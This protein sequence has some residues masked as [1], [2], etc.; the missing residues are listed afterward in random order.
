MLPTSEIRQMRNRVRSLQIAKSEK[1][2][3]LCSG[4][5]IERNRRGG[6]ILIYTALS[7]VAMLGCC[8]LAVDYGLQVSDANKLQRSLDAAALAGAQELK[9]NYDRADEAK[10]RETAVLTASQNGTS[11]SAADDISFGDGSSSITVRGHIVR[12]YLFA[13]VFNMIVPGSASS[14]R[15]DRHATARV[16]SCSAVPTPRVVPIGIT[17]DTYGGTDPHGYDH[18]NGY[19]SDWM[20]NKLLL[21]QPD[22]MIYRTLTLARQSATVFG[23]DEVV[24]FDLRNSP[25]KSGPHFVAQLT[26]DE[27]AAA[28][29]SI[30][31]VETTLNA[32]DSSQGSR[33]A[34][35]F[36]TIF[37]RAAGAPW[38]DGTATPIINA[39]GIRLPDL[40]SGTSP[41]DSRDRPNPRVMSL[42]VTPA[43]IAAPVNG[44]WDTPVEGY[45]PV[46]VKRA[47]ATTDPVTGE[48]V[49]KM[50]AAFLPPQENSN[51]T[52]TASQN[53]AVTGQ[54]VIALVD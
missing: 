5:A 45:A 15:V 39:V 12:L 31:D 9:Q 26:G 2:C 10:A 42:I 37:G 51:G 33:L 3:G 11:I 54:R 1:R 23:R 17:W 28:L 22:R 35:A 24:L 36:S 21:D 43:P 18:P 14:G 13:R 16:T 38:N 48:T 32:S 44:S 46:Y 50:D 20:E 4:F 41:L 47:Y 34:D 52:C 7:I 25:S 53:A 27:T 19:R 49:Y 40:L 29:S 8:A 30:G 6:S